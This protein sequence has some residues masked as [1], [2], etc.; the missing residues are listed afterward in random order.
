MELEGY[1]LVQRAL[2]LA[3]EI[4]KEINNHPLISKYFHAATPAEMIPPE[5][6]VTGFSDY[7][8]PGST[9]SDATQALRKDEFFLD[10]TR[11]TLLCGNAGYDGTRFNG[12]ACRN[13]RHPDQ[14]D[15]AQ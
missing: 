3:M 5:Y 13:L 15:V 10:P 4:R 14:Q 11:I 8:M 1:E 12:T 2:Q 6:R 9:V 7:G